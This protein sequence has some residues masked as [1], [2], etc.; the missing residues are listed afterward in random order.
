M[1]SANTDVCYG[2]K[3]DI[4]SRVSMRLREQGWTPYALRL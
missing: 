1:C 4:R 2:P 3:A